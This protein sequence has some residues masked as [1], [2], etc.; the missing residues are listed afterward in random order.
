MFLKLAFDLALHSPEVKE[1][2]N[3]I[4]L[5]HTSDETL[6]VLIEE[7]CRMGCKLSSFGFDLTGQDTYEAVKEQIERTCEKNSNDLPFI[8]SATDDVILVIKADPAHPE[9]LYSRVRGLCTKLD[10]E[11]E[12]I[13][14]SFDNDKAHLLMSPGWATPAAS[15]LPAR[16]KIRSDDHLLV[17]RQGIEVVG[18]PVG[19]RAYCQQ[20]V[21]SSLKQMLQHSNNLEHIHPQAAAKIL[22]TCL[23]QAPVYLSQVCHPSVTRKEFGKFDIEVW[24]LWTAILG[25]VGDEAEQLKLCKAGESRANRWTSLPSREGGVGLRWWSTVGEYAWYGSF[26]WCDDTDFNNGKQFLKAECEHTHKKALE[27][28]GGKLY[29]NHGDYEVLP[30]EDKDVLYA[31]DFDYYTQW[32]KDHQSVKLQQQFNRIVGERLRKDLTSDTQLKHEHVTESEKVRAVQTRKDPQ[33]SVLLH[34][35]Q[36]S[37]ADNESRLTPLEY[38]IAARQFIGLPALKNPRAETVEL[39]CGCKVQK[40]PNVGCDAQLDPCGNHA[41]TCHVG[42]GSRKA[43]LL[44]RTLERTF[45][46]SCGKGESQPS[47]SKLLG[48][49]LPT[50]DL[51]RLFPGGLSVEETK[52]N[53]D[54]AIELIDAFM[55]SAPTKEAI[56]DEGRSRMPV[57][58]EEKEQLANSVVRFDL[59]LGSQF[60]YELP[61]QLWMDHGITQETCDTSCRR[62]DAARRWS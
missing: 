34:L 47:T 40:C 35:F 8:K 17:D 7:G 52:K 26:A 31:Q 44:E 15:E 37:L 60:P 27:I 12:K 41:M 21:R 6:L 42:I 61:M 39:K 2:A 13:G 25:G 36:G 29:I 32:R 59:K 54:L 53:Q 20:Y 51:V 11:A 18:S 33:G 9:K 16:L 4:G 55:T 56:I 38:K 3:S 5:Y 57:I 49:M 58:D 43:T 24:K 10:I 48:E 19:S 28:L 23:A 50:E 45:R 30:P 14:I 46:A 22:L 1:A 62:A